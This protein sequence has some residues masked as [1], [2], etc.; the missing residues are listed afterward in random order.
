A[1]ALVLIE[2][3][4]SAEHPVL[5]L[6]GNRGVLKRRSLLARR[7]ARLLVK[8]ARCLPRLTR[9]CFLT[10]E[11]KLRLSKLEIFVQRDGERCQFFHDS[12]FLARALAGNSQCKEH[13]NAGCDGEP[14]SANKGGFRIG[15]QRAKHKSLHRTN[16]T[17]LQVLLTR[18]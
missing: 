14:H 1:K 2:P 7:I 17:E 13:Q 11:E 6:K 15:C 3:R 4:D 9:F 8:C 10:K 18:I 5:A 12:R 16:V